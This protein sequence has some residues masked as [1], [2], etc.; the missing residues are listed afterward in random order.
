M[1]AEPSFDAWLQEARQSSEAALCGMFLAHCG[2]VRATPKAQV[3]EG[4]VGLPRVRALELDCDEAAL[5]AALADARAYPGVHYLRVWVNSG[6]LTVG[7]TMMVVLV[8]ADI[9]PH[10]VDALERLVENI[11]TNV[12]TER[13]CYEAQGD[14]VAPA[15]VRG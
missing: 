15:A 8:G 10:C 12:V 11:K 13:E 6:M 1:T 14:S 7:D 9:R 3:R 2:V 5:E 4:K